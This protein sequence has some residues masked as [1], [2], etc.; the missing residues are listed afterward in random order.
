[1]GGHPSP[2]VTLGE[3]TI[4]I[5]LGKL[6]RPVYMRSRKVVSRGKGDPG[7]RVIRFAR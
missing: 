7:G 5:F 4:N 3:T 2:R 1:M 6:Q